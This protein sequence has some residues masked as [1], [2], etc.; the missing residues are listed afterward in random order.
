MFGLTEFTAQFSEPTR[1]AIIPTF[2][3]PFTVLGMILT[4]LATWVAAFFG[5]KLKAEGP[6]RLFE[7]LMKPKILIWAL[8]SNLVFYGAFAGGKALFYSSRPLW[9]IQARNSAEVQDSKK[10]S[11]F[12]TQNWIE[13]G[14]AYA[15]PREIQGVDVLWQADAGGGIFGGLIASGSSLFFGTDR[16]RLFELDSA[17]GQTLRQI[18]TGQPIMTTPLVQDGKVYFGE[19]V[20][21]THHARYYQ[22]DLSLGKITAQFQTRGHIER[23]AV[24]TE[25]AGQKIFLL[26]AGSDGVWALDPQNMKA[27]WQAKV[28]H[29]DSFPISDG[30]SVFVGTGQE[31]GFPESETVALAL[32]LKNGKQIWKK[33]LPVSAW[34]MPMLWKNSVCFSLGDVYQNTKYGQV[35]CYD[36]ATGREE[37]AVNL[38]G[39]VLAQPILAGDHL[40]LTDLQGVIYQVSLTEKKIEWQIQVPMSGTNFAPVVLDSEDRLFLPG[41]DGLYVY[42]RK[43]QSL[44]YHWKAPKDWERPDSNLLVNNE[45]WIVSDGR[46]KIWALKPQ[47]SKHRLTQN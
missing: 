43:T 25:L 33:N 32:D 41:D 24:A 17:T 35:A 20:H 15:N 45:T 31:K 30:H 12:Q 4:S 46:G 14:L 1:L 10:Y 38:P 37:V 27:L 42:S 22:L 28:G 5:I 16:G 47:F 26:P 8:V 18:W 21:E 29:V 34:G 39:A 7:V 13:K 11:D 36:K 44:L 9:L 23:T 2:V 40:I 3:L 6:K 19:G